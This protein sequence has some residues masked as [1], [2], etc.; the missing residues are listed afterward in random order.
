MGASIHDV[1]GGLALD[2]RTGGHTHAGL[3]YGG[4]CFPKDVRALDHLGLANGVNLELLRAVINVNNRQR[5][6]P[7]YALRKRFGGNMV[8]VLGLAFKPDTDDVREAPGIDLIRALV[9]DGAIVT[10]YDPQAT[11]NARNHLPPAVR[12]AATPP[13]AAIEAQA[14]VLV[15]EWEQCVAADWSDIASR[16]RPP[17]LVF[18]GRNALSPA[19]MQRLGFQYVGIGARAPATN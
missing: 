12:F 7:L 9:A 1:S 18:D 2:P 16:M 5:L 17:R 6:L 4:S 14:V 10:A 3:G 8:G 13:E 11:A 15:T 19:E